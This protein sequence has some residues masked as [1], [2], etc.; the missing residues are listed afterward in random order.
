MA[1]SCLE[2]YN[3][4][5]FV[6]GQTGS[7]KTHTMH[8]TIG[9][10]MNE[11]CP[12]R[13]LVPRTLEHLF[14]LVAREERKSD[15]VGF[16]CKAS[17]LEIYNEN[18]VDL[19]DTTSKVL[20]LREDI[21]TGVYVEDLKE[22]VV[23]GPAE[24]LALLQTGARNR[25]VG[26]TSMNRESSRSHSVFTFTVES[27]Q[28]RDG[29]VH[30]KHSRLHLIDLA[31]SERQ[32]STGAIG[33]TLKEASN[34]NKSLSALGNVIMALVNVSTGK[35]RHVPY[36]DSKLTFLLKDSLGGNSRTCIIANVSP[37]D[38]NFGE[39]LSTL[40]FAQ[41]AKHIRTEAKI[42]EDSSGS[43]DILQREIRRLKEELLSA[44]S[45]APLMIEGPST[46][47]SSSSSS[48]VSSGPSNNREL[49]R[50]LSQ[51][52]T[53]SKIATEAA[54]AAAARVEA[55]EQNFA[56]REQAAQNSKMVLKFRD[57]E[58]ARLR[59]EV[60]AALA[61]QQLPPVEAG[62]N[63]ALVAE[64]R[65][66]IRI[67]QARSDNHPEA[68]RLSMEVSK[69]QDELRV[70]RSHAQPEAAEEIARVK[71]L[72]ADVSAQLVAVIAE[73]H[74]LLDRV[75][76]LEAS[77]QAP[78]TSAPAAYE[79]VMSPSP[80]VRNVRNM[81]SA[82][83]MSPQRRAVIEAL[84]QERHQLREVQ[85]RMS[86]ELQSELASARKDAEEHAADAEALRV[87][88][89]AASARVTELQA[90]SRASKLIDE[91][92]IRQL[93]SM[94]ESL[95]QQTGAAA[96]QRTTRGN[97]RVAEELAA[98]QAA[99][100]QLRVE[101]VGKEAELEE[102]RSRTATS[103]AEVEALKQAVATSEA[104]RSA[105][106]RRVADAEAIILSAR[107]AFEKEQAAT[108]A[109]EMLA[110]DAEQRSLELE[111]RLGRLGTEFAEAEEKNMV[112]AERLEVAEQELARAQEQLQEQQ[113]QLQQL[114][115][116]EPSPQLDD[117][118]DAT[119]ALE[120]AALRTEVEALT[121]RLAA[122]EGE[123]ARDAQSRGSLMASLQQ[124]LIAAREAAKDFS[125]QLSSA[126]SEA[127]ELQAALD[128]SSEERA[129]ALASI[130][131]LSAAQ[132][133]VR[134]ETASALADR[135]AALADLREVQAALERKVK[136]EKEAKRSE[137]KKKCAAEAELESSRAEAERLR[138]ALAEAQEQLAARE[139]E[140]RSTTGN[141]ANE[142]ALERLRSQRLEKDAEALREKELAL[143]Q[144]VQQLDA[145]REEKNACIVAL[146]GTVAGL[147]AQVDDAAA[148]QARQAHA[149]AD[150]DARYCAA[151]A[152]TRAAEEAHKN[153][154]G[155]LVVKDEEAL[156]L[157]AKTK[158]LETQLAGSREEMKRWMD[159]M[160][161]LKK[162][163]ERAFADAQAQREANESLRT[164]NLALEREAKQ[165][166]ESV[167]KLEAEVAKLSGHQNQKQ[168]IHYHQQLK[169]E[170]S[171][172]SKSV[173]ELS[174]LVA[175]KDRVI[176]R[177]MEGLENKDPKATSA[178]AAA[179]ASSHKDKDG[180]RSLPFDLDLEDALRAEIKEAKE[181]E[182]ARTKEVKAQ[183]AAV[184]KAA[185]AQS[186]QPAVLDADLVAV[187]K[188]VAKIVEVKAKE[189]QA[190]ERAL[191]DKDFQI[192]M[193]AKRAVIE[194]KQ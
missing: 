28:S 23:A 152:L 61:G 131:S 42:N 49:E 17:F 58:I 108:Q 114:R 37:A 59:K 33:Q 115:L 77:R 86:K 90:S 166:S 72:A 63:S 164:H 71:A 187:V 21:K 160:A 179:A 124:E 60:A 97:F 112:L 46:S 129:A 99:R 189:L 161:R 120:L 94:V 53:D 68:T 25:T 56:K 82:S 151:Q 172:S 6:Y 62:E 102:I 125:A 163:E 134:A 85:E 24:A 91:A 136:E 4:A 84:E 193:L 19:L 96:N 104:A 41:R 69:L 181:A 70:A 101:L 51:A 122:A 150:L 35:A 81:D 80:L 156:R 153:A 109:A 47:S 103:A 74:A 133:A 113:Q 178:A 123:A 155:Q 171:Q 40:Q 180:Q 22:E 30:V 146:Q 137:R 158:V 192:E 139:D 14:A 10:E 39:T 118:M 169:Q 52:L 107:K 147:R 50:L 194:S 92:K 66:E 145:I 78:S 73:K 89:D 190:A 65:E 176:A 143:T 165:A 93:Q 126:R 117:T 140:L 116:R 48:S 170:L 188:S 186:A 95:Q 45:G 31:G 154:L 135:E 105:L 12:D 162:E 142:L 182:E 128:A 54:K 127:S 191:K 20:H 100:D 2:G 32:K 185:G 174:D 184:L 5:V 1:E 3:G 121:R 119:A 18:I 36:R 167:T 175:K 27:K 29:L 15:S 88:L 8:G 34:I 9:S 183:L 168:K 16:L 57:A 87:Q 144:V 98:A 148:T 106:A 141:V 149:L 26:A 132:E 177:L 110:K 64:L 157:A 55:T 38:I 76:A 111:A 7:G 44:R 138:A 130:D 83:T 173:Q 43:T 13:G 79:G 159:D 11:A 67:L 75:A